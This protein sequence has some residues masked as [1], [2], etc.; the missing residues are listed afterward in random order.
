MQFIP[1]IP[2]I[3]PSKADKTKTLTIPLVKIVLLKSAEPRIR[4]RAMYREDDKT[5]VTNPR[6]ED[7]LPQKNEA[8]KPE[9]R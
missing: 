3:P 5:P 9:K 1:N 6:L 7:A 8:K 2:P 4:R